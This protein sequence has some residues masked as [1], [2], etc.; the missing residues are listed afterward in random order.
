MA[1]D[2]KAEKFHRIDGRCFYSSVQRDND[3][4]GIEYDCHSNE[5]KNKAYDREEAL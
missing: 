4:V 2:I 3:I 1:E 5:V